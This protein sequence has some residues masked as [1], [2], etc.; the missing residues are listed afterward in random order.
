MRKLSLEAY[1]A[2]YR[3]FREGYMRAF[4]RLRELYFKAD[5]QIPLVIC[6][7]QKCPECGTEI[8]ISL[9]QGSEQFPIWPTVVP[10]IRSEST[11]DGGR[12]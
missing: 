2:Y 4:E 1:E 9:S 10:G 3:G 6:L 12:K 5:A 8:P 7:R 11:T